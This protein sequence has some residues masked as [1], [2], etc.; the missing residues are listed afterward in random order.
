MNSRAT[1]LNAE[2]LTPVGI[3]VFL[4]G[5]LAEALR[6]GWIVKDGLPSE[7]FFPVLLFVLGFPVAVYLLI[8][9]LLKTKE[10]LETAVPVG[11]VPERDGGSSSKLVVDVKYKPFF[12]T[13]LTVAFIVLFKYLGYT[14]SAPIYIFLFQ[15]IYDD[16]FGNYLRKIIVSVIVS[17]LVYVLYVGFF[18]ILFPEVWK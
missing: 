13:V 1:Y 4:L 18:N 17:V 15:L 9:G 6:M 7:S 12:I 10:K 3:I 11:A 5:Y 14:I 16:E 8:H 2:V